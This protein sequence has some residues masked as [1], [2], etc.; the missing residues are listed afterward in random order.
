MTRVWGSRAGSQSD[1]NEARCQ[2]WWYSSTSNRA[3]S[4]EQQ[5]YQNN[6]SMTCQTF[7]KRERVCLASNAA[8]YPRRFQ[9][10]F[11]GLCHIRT[12]LRSW[13]VIQVCRNLQAAGCSD[14]GYKR[15]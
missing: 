13:K 3:V 14:A 6:N 5:M 11:V 8:M 7:R 9:A 15:T 12:P 10:G 2:S 4:L 1:D